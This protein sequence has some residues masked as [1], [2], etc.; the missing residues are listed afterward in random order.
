[1]GS[2]DEERQSKPLTSF[3]VIWT[4]QAF[5]LVG[6]QLVQFAL[7]WWLTKTTGSA[8]V[9]AF[10]T[11]MAL[12]PQIL[13][14]PIAGALVDRWDRRRVLILADGSIALAT[15]VLATLYALDLV[16][17]W[18]IYALMFVRSAGAAFHWPAMQAS[19]TLMVPDRHLSRVAGLNQTVAGLG[20]IGAPPLG[21]LLLELLPMQVILAVDVGTAILAILPLL[22][23]AIPQPER[24]AVSTSGGV[25]SSVLRDM[26][27]GLRLIWG[28]PGMLLIIA[29]AMLLN[30][31]GTPALS[32][33]PILVS[34]HFSG[35]AVEFAW[36]ESGWG[37]GMVLGGLTLGA[38]GGFNRRIVTG[39]AAL[40]LQGIAIFCVGLVPGTAFRF[41][42]GA[43]LLTGFMNPI[44]NGSLYATVQA[45]VEPQMQGRVFTLLRSGAW[46]MTPLGLAVAGPL[47][48]VVSVQA[49]F[50]LAGVATTA[51][52]LSAFFV[53]AVMNIEERS[54]GADAQP[55][56]EDGGV[57]A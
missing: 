37:V 45:V 13:L 43:I 27:A 53:P 34:E 35:G 12:L 18:H 31:L 32:L 51:M 44:I 6:S 21:A 24:L 42:L 38:W 5:S 7:V 16:Q 2:M 55:R 4:G 54:P 10:A 8:T 26:R 41:A 14:G 30:L 40:V 39:M 47:A 56:Q 36:L 50:L 9:L 57:S 11:M 23:V 33:L 17:V 22:F 48:D 25:V 52:G 3:F 20:N 1:M 19:T 28:W 46:A 49:W 15:I 29:F